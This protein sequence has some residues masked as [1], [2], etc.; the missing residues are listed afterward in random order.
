MKFQISYVQNWAENDTHS[1]QQRWAGNDAHQQE[2]VR[3][4][5]EQRSR[6]TRATFEIRTTFETRVKNNRSQHKRER[7]VILGKAESRYCANSINLFF[8][9][10]ERGKRW[11]CTH[12]VIRPTRYPAWRSSLSTSFT[13]GLGPSAPDATLSRRDKA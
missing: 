10:K 12:R 5:H 2:H 6:E 3:E 7:V 9:E 1:R 11:M 13:E 8:F 4:R